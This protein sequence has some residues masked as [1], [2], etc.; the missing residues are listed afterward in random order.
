MPAYTVLYGFRGLDDSEKIKGLSNFKRIVLEEVSQFDEV[1]FKQVKKRLRGKDG[2]QIVGIFNPISEDSWIK[3]K[4]FDNEILT[5]IDC[6]ITSM[7]VNESKDT[8]ILKTNYT[9]NIFIVGRFDKDNNLVAGRVDTHVINDF[10]KDKNGKSRSQRF[11]CFIHEFNHS[12]FRTARSRRSR[13][14]WSYETISNP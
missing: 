11:Q 10:E 2:Q 5:D 12:C 8:I 4:V 1:D 6:D 13:T 7:Q 3:T 14:N 9:D